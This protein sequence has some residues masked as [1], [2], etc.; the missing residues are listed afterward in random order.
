MSLDQFGNTDLQKLILLVNLGILHSLENDYITINEAEHFLYTPF[1][2][3]LLKKNKYSK[4]LI[5]VI[6]R[7]TELED[8]ESF[9]LDVKNELK[10]MFK[11]CEV[12]IKQLPESSCQ[13]DKWYDQKLFDKYK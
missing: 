5:D 11:E 1:M 9:N 10:E 12:L 7:G 8:L 13:F 4:N 3:N 6:H 2:M